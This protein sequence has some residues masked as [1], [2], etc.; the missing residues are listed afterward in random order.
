MGAR[1]AALRALRSAKLEANRSWTINYPA[2]ELGGILAYFYK[3]EKN[4]TV[5]FYGI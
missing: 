5:S 4:E 1:G 3:K 2:A